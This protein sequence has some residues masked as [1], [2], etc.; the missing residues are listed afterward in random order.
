M[1]R[2]KQDASIAFFLVFVLTAAL[3]FVFSEVHHLQQETD[4]LST[5]V[6]MATTQMQQ[7]T[8]DLENSLRAAN[9][10]AK[11]LQLTIDNTLLPK[12]Q[13]L[14]TSFAP[15]SAVSSKDDSIFTRAG[16][17]LEQAKAIRQELDPTKR[18]A[19]G[20][21]LRDALKEVDVSSERVRSVLSEARTIA[22][23]STPATAAGG[24]APSL[25]DAL[26]DIESKAVSTKNS[27]TTIQTILG[28]PSKSDSL[29][30]TMQQLRDTIYNLSNIK[31][32]DWSSLQ[33]SLENIE[34][35]QAKRAIVRQLAGFSEHPPVVAPHDAGAGQ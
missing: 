26:Q 12:V 4:K 7:V 20:L 13:A 18:V 5:Q 28:T 14:K 22:M 8:K 15:A 34:Q 2:E 19:G 24:A 11:A 21:T 6:G 3:V 16:V 33:K 23:T 25:R 31:A 1:K 9:E 30:A 32:A 17:V 10:S 35:D 27:V 29:S